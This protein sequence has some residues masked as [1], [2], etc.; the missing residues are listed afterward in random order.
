MP[1]NTFKHGSLTGYYTKGCRCTVCTEGARVYMARR[2]AEMRA[3]T[4]AGKI[5]GWVTHGKASTY[6]NWAC[7][8]A[9]C[10][11]AVRYR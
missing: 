6:A 11:E 10:T 4:E 7:R 2:R 8:C 5:P 3:L 1:T 9:A